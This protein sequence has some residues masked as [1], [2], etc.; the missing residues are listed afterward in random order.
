[1][2]WCMTV[3]VYTLLCVDESFEY[4]DSRIDVLTQQCVVELERQGF[5]R[6]SLNYTPLSVSG[7]P[8]GRWLRPPPTSIYATRGLTVPSCVHQP[9]KRGVVNVAMEISR[10]HSPSGKCTLGTCSGCDF[11]SVVLIDYRYQREFGFTIPSRPIVVDDIRVRGTARACSHHPTPLPPTE[12]PP[13]RETVSRDGDGWF[14]LLDYYLSQVTTCCFEGGVLDTDVYLLSR[15]G[16]G[17]RITGPAIIIDKNRWRGGGWS[18][19]P[20]LWVYTVEESSRTLRICQFFN[21]LMW[22]MN[23]S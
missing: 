18:N 3:H 4:I 21:A 13:H 20:N 15:L 7:P 19:T 11:W 8:P 1:M 22:C 14:W 2:C 12:D 10:R 17:H 23:W 6:Y 9:S 16:R 5:Q